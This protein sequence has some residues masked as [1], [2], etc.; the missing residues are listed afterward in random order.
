MDDKVGFH[1]LG[2]MIFTGVRILL[3]Y[4]QGSNEIMKLEILYDIDVFCSGWLVP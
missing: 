2:S 1:E 3:Y 4:G